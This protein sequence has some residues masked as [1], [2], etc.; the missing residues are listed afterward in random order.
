MVEELSTSGESHN[1]ITFRGS[2]EVKAETPLDLVRAGITVSPD[3]VRKTWGEEAALEYIQAV[4]N[5]VFER[6]KATP[7][8]KRG[9]SVEN[10][11]A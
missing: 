8:P 1:A 3:F 9:W 5:P 4:R 6:G 11:N 2:R 10:R 7:E